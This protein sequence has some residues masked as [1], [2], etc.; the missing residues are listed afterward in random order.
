MSTIY[1]V[2]K[3]SYFLQYCVLAYSNL[4]LDIATSKKI[5][6]IT[7]SIPPSFT[8]PLPPGRNAA[9]HKKSRPCELLKT[10]LP[11]SSSVKISILNPGGRLME[12]REPESMDGMMAGFMNVMAWNAAMFIKN[13][14]IIRN[15]QITFH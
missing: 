15:I 1:L 12:S 8:I 10:G 11:P 3:Y 4:N 5:T 14:M 2:R 9:C 7:K 6:A 13:A